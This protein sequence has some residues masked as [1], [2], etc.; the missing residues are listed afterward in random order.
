MLRPRLL[1]HWLLYYTA[2]ECECLTQG[3]ANTFGILPNQKRDH[4]PLEVLESGGPGQY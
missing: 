4:P 3:V 1:P 2:A